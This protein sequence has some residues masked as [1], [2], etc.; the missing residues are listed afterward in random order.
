MGHRRFLTLFAAVALF[1]GALAAQAPPA[2]QW[3][4]L[5]QEQ[6][7]PSKVADFESS[8][9]EFIALVNQ[10]R[11]TMPDFSFNCLQGEDFMYTFVVPIQGFGGVDKVMANFGAYMQA[12][13][14]KAAEIFSRSGASYEYTNEWVVAQAPELGYQPEKPRLKI[15]D[16]K[17][18]HY[19]MYHLM[20]GKEQ[21]ADAI[22]KD[23]S[24]LFRAKGVANGY[25]IYKM[26]MG[27]EMPTLIVEQWAKD[28]A[29]FHSEVAKNTALLAGADQ[30]LFARA[31]AITRRFES[32]KAW[33]RPDLS[34]P[35]MAKK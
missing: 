18:F 17:F 15:E 34:L 12:A 8:T 25:N 33:A 22:G 23:F 14:P 32:V 9:K 35:P 19:S 24:A 7:K 11:A 10:H 28:E 29:E 5:H 2:G 20:P 21:E 4:L 13:G 6:A 27:Q 3:Y 1:A 16:A 30:P 26:M 31:M